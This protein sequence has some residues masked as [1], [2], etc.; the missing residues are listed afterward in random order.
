M[1]LIVLLVLIAA[2]AG[3]P[4]AVMLAH[5]MRDNFILTLLLVLVFA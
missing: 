3:I 5:W 1:I 2:A 4:E